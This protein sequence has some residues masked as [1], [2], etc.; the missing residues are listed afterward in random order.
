[1]SATAAAA[2]AAVAASAQATKHDTCY[3]AATCCCTAAP[4]CLPAGDKVVADGVVIES[5]GLVVDEASLT[6]E[7]DPIK[8]SDEDPWCRSGTQVCGCVGGVE[9]GAAAARTPGM[10]AQLPAAYL[11][12]LHAA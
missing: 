8:K 10:T 11:R 4:A 6:G 2:A 5:H 9:S 1:M 12:E 3:V 7:S